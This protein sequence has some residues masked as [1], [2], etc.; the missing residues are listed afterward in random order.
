[1]QRQ[2]GGILPESPTTRIPFTLQNVFAAIQIVG[3]GGTSKRLCSYHRFDEARPAEPTRRCQR[4]RDQLQAF[5]TLA[6]I[7][8]PLHQITLHEIRSRAGDRWGDISYL[9]GVVR[10]SQGRGGDK[11]RK[12]KKKKKVEKQDES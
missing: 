8:P 5:T 4:P 11:W 1:M 10:K 6:A 12:E 2:R 9:L 3:A 7:S